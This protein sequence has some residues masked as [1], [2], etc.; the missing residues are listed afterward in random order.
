MT[1]VQ[2]P[3]TFK[4]HPLTGWLGGLLALVM[5]GAG[6]WLLGQHRELGIALIAM[7]TFAAFGAFMTLRRD[8]YYLTLTNEGFEFAGILRKKFVAWRDVE[9]FVFVPVDR[10]NDLDRLGW[11]YTQRSGLVRP[12]SH[13]AGAYGFCDELFPTNY[14]GISHQELSMLLNELVNDARGQ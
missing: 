13:R 12:D 1:T 6:I 8:R 9:K 10:V 2:L 11:Q 5:V 14:R 3:I 7:S 4:A